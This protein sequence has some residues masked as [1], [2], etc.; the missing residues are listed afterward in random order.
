M[1]WDLG[2]DLGS[3]SGARWATL[4]V[5]RLLK[6][7]S[8]LA[9][10]TLLSGVV[11]DAQTGLVRQVLRGAPDAG[12]PKTHDGENVTGA[13]DLYVPATKAAPV[14]RPQKAAKDKD[15]GK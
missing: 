8:L 14:F 6:A 3:G 10:L 1:G 2:S 12:K 11:L 13:D 5:M 15:G 4:T 9:F 7:F